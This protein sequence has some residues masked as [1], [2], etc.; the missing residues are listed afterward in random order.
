MTHITLNNAQSIA[1]YSWP[2]VAELGFA[3]DAEQPLTL[4]GSDVIRH[5]DESCFG[6]YSNNGF[7]RDLS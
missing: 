7:K 1:R 4:P 5:E 3:S 6:I 2:L